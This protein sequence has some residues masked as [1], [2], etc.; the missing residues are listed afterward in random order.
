ML[1]DIMLSIITVCYNSDKTIEDTIISILCQKNS[2]IQYIIID[3][4][5]NDNTLNIINKY[6]NNIDIVVSE[7]DNGMYDALNKGIALCKGQIIGQIN[8]DDY[9]HYGALNIA[10]NEYL[11]RPF[12]WLYGDTIIIK[13]DNTK[14]RKT[15]RQWKD[16]YYGNPEFLHSACFFSKKILNNIGGYNPKYK[17]AGDIDLFQR[18][19]LETDNIRYINQ[20]ISYQRSGG[21]S[22]AG[23]GFIKGFWEY[24][25]INIKNGLSR[26]K[27]SYYFIKKTIIRLL[28]MLKN[29]CYAETS[30]EKKA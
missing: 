22:Q 28:I 1:C 7:P 15:A 25:D 8:A 16:M 13:N 18:V 17:I 3:G 4:N 6:S 2:N 19:K 9:Y 24:R 10:I 12:D 14:V 26:H 20:L 21:M 30:N 27:A 11:T 5:S 29:K 23:Y